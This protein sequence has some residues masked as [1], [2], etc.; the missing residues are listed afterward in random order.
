MIRLLVVGKMKERGLA[1]RC[2]TY[3]K[4]IRPWAPIEVVELKDQDGK[5]EDSFPASFESLYERRTRSNIGEL[6]NIALEAIRWSAR[7]T[8]ALRRKTIC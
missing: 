5:I 2:A 6:I 8:A 7:P 1:E 3:L 4:R